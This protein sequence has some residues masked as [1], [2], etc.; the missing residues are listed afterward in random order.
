M[1]SG[2]QRAPFTRINGILEWAS[3]DPSAEIEWQ[4]GTTSGGVAYHKIYRETQLLWSE[5]DDQAEWGYWYLASKGGHGLSHQSGS[6]TTVRNQFQH[7]GTLTNKEDTRYRAINDSFPTFAFAQDLGRVSSKA[8]STLFDV[9][10]AQNQAIQFDSAK[11]NVSVPSL[12]T[13]Y[14]ST[15]DAALDFHY[16]DYTTAFGMATSFDQQVASDSMAAGGQNYL[17]ITSL[18]ARQAFGTTQLCGTPQ[19]MYLFL[20][21]ISSDGNVQTVDVIFPFHPILA[22]TNPMLL[23]LLLDPL[24]ENQES[25]QYPNTYSMHDL[26]T[27]YPNATGHALGDDE[28]QPLEECG[29]MLIM[30][31]AYAQRAPNGIDTAYLNQHYK[32]LTQWTQYLVNDSLIPANQISTDDFA[33]SLANQTNLALKGIIG[34]RAMAQIANLTGHL[35]DGR[36]YTNISQVYINKWQQYGIAMNAKPPHT[37]LGYGLN[38]TH[39][40]L[41]NLFGDRELNLNLVPQRVYDMQSNFYP[42]V[43]LNYGVPLDTRHNYTKADWQMFTAAIAGKSTQN[44]FIRDL[45]KWIG[46]TPTN[47]P[48]S[49]LFDAIAGNFPPGITFTNRPVMGGAF[50]LLSLNGAANHTRYKIGTEVAPPQ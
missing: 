49:D 4:Y 2:A 25:G 47:L 42:T 21:E 24:F 35:A 37:T 44:M 40:L 13:S 9:G 12:W 17:T 36:K 27:H 5:T 29:N 45:A 46:Q 14:F 26:G 28:M 18:S 1:V 3:G 31:L 11:G 8:V 20:K 19:K 41:Y 48:F 33:G 7:H 16:H 6:N 32:I 50:A 38:K 10:L 23:K 43:E 22:Y 39:G 15:G 34:I 30:T